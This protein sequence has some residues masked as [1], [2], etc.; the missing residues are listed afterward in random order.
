[1]ST[2][3]SHPHDPQPRDARFDAS[4]R[5][6]HRAAL[7]NVSPQVRWKLRPAQQPSQRETARRRFGRWLPAPLLAGAAAAVLA[8]ALGIG[9]WPAEQAAPGATP[10][11]TVDS[12]DGAGVLEQD[13]DF[14]AWLASDDASLVAME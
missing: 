4:M 2:H 1:M 10:V 5:G 3:D 13:P 12:D 9:L 8:V 11:A 14:Y 7:A 6:L